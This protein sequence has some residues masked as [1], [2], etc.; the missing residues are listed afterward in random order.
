[1]WRTFFLAALATAAMA[2]SPIVLL[3]GWH[4]NE[5]R[6]HYRWDGK[7]MGGFS[8]LD[9]LLAELGADRRT[10]T[11][12]LTAAVLA[13]ARCLII[14]DPDTPQ[15]TKTPNYIQPAEIDA[16]GNWVKQGGRLILLGNDPGN[17]EFHHFNRLAQQFGIR[18]R[19]SKH[20]DEQGRTKLTL[21]VP[22]N[23]NILTGGGAFYA[24]DVAP[25]EITAQSAQ[26]LVAERETPIMALVRYGKGEVVALG[27][28]WI[29]D[30]YINT[31]DNRK[32]AASL[33]RYLLHTTLAANR[34]F[35][36][37]AWRQ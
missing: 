25:L 5:E 10:A 2:Q 37:P 14:V 28:P 6:P 34:L 23:Q 19:E 12:P 26:I 21:H 9:K 7:Y 3:D 27:D 8:E 29:Y 18:F 36:N 31:R 30:E 33:F 16:I 11:G 20:A 24:V 15:E 32:L 1:M 22:T 13:P 17:A 35:P 4:N